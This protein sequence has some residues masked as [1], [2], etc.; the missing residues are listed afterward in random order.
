ML[1]ETSAE[2]SGE[3]IPM[4]GSTRRVVIT[5]RGLISSL[6]NNVE[7]VFDRLLAGDSAVRFMDH[8]PVPA[9]A[10][11][12][13][14]P[15]RERLFQRLPRSRSRSMGKV[16]LYSALAALDALEDSGLQDISGP[17]TACVAGST[18]GSSEVLEETFRTLLLG[19]GMQNISPMNFFKCS[20]HTAAYNTANVL[21]I[22]GAVYAPSAACA[23]GLQSIGLASLLIASGECK[24]AVAGGSEELSHMVSESFLLMDA[25]AKAASGNRDFREYP[26]PFDRERN[27]LVCGEGSGI[28]ILEEYEHARKRGAV[29]HGEIVSFASNR[30]KDTV[31][32]SDTGA[33]EECLERLFSG[34]SS[35]NIKEISYINAHA[36][37]TLQGDRSEAEALRR[38][39][40]GSVPVS[41]LKGALGHTLGASGSL[42]LILTLEMMKRGLILPTLNL[43]E[44]S[45]DC[46]GLDHVMQVREKPLNCFIKNAFAFGSINASILCRK[47]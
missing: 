41:S 32:Q 23:S 11:A 31:S 21:G 17:E 27:G 35:D 7:K 5:G 1:Q 4:N 37:G 30:G 13:E 40:R 6:G 43:K 16:A 8:W 47:I 2:H 3:Q 29:I 28:V 38:Y 46:A 14:E 20:S 15:E 24:I 25:H 45:E 22:T 10:A 26:K 12:L 42:E 33:V 19:Q 9:P 18:M 44:P 36:T 34:S 39:F